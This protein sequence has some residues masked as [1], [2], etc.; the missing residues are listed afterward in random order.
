M[1]ALV[2]ECGAGRKCHRA[3]TPRCAGGRRDQPGE[4]GN[5]GDAG[6]GRTKTVRVECWLARQLDTYFI[7]DNTVEL[8]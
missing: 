4:R 1:A 7:H 5:I 8:R 2:A 3:R 6:A